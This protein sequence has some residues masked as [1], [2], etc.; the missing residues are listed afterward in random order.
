M[1]VREL[2]G[3]AE[4][5]AFGTRAVAEWT[6]DP[7]RESCGW[8]FGVQVPFWLSYARTGGLIGGL[9]WF[10]PAPCRVQ[11]CAVCCCLCLDYGSVEMNFRIRSQAARWSADT[12][13]CR[14]AFAT[15]S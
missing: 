9:S 12:S 6:R 3:L 4:T 5:L 11:C 13:N 2:R 15:L 1:G 10:G 8:W 14:L 7:S